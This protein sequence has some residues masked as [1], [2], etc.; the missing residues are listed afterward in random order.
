MDSFIFVE[1]VV[2]RG[3][4]IIFREPLLK[5]AVRC[6]ILVHLNTDAFFQIVGKEE[7][8]MLDFQKS[9]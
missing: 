9:I 5:E 1:N 4:S 8:Q 3:N 7:G 6:R 2:L